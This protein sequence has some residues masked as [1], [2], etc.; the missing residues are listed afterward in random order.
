MGSART[1][2]VLCVGVLAAAL[3]AAADAKSFTFAV[4]ADAYV[5][6]SSANSNFGGATTLRAGTSPVTRSYLRFTVGGL[7]GGT[8]TK[9]TL[10][11]QPAS[12]SSTGVTV[13]RVTGSWSEGTITFANAPAPLVASGDPVSGGVTSGSWLSVNVTRFVTGEGSVSLALVRDSSGTLSFRSQEAGSGSAPRLVVE[14]KDPPPPPPPPPAPSPPRTFTYPPIADAY[15]G[16][17]APSTSFGTDPSLRV[18]ATPERRSYLRFSVTGLGLAPT[19]ATLRL[20]AS[21]A[22]GD[23][24]VRRVGDTAW[25][26]AITYESAPPVTVGAA[27][28]AAPAAAAGW[29]DVDV[30]PFVSGNGP[31]SLALTTTSATET[32]LASRERGGGFAPQLIVQTP[33]VAPDGSLA[34]PISATFYYPWFPDGWNQQG[35]NCGLAPPAGSPATPSG[36]FTWYTPSAGF[37]S[38]DGS[39]G[40]ATIDAHVRALQAAG[41]EA[42]IASWW[43]VGT[44]TDSR[45]SRLLSR[46]RAL[47]SPLKWALYYEQEGYGNPTV[48]EIQSDLAYIANTKRYSSNSAYLRVGGAPVLFVYT[49]DDVDCSVGQ[50]WQ[51]AN[52]SFG[53]HLVFKVFWGYWNCGLGADWHQYGPAVPEDDQKGFS[54]SISP[55]FWKA[56]EAAPRLARDLARWTANIA[57]MRAANVHWRL[58]TSFNEWGE[59]T[60]IESANE[61]ATPS[62]YGAYLDA[63]RPS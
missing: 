49:A 61:W 5:N 14:T 6:Q 8:V 55:G 54:F 50:R 1:L 4:N 37:Y 36:C 3:P 62:R 42:A 31:V 15:V 56:G 21:Q 30:T 9:A 63:L 60:S 19:K 11:L 39:A 16:A 17:D 57:H 44:P 35:Y 58:V 18:A 41:Q 48:A 43:G 25:T 40:D 47:A 34:W 10:R 12:T 51:T 22:T 32:V 7:G 29:V 13:R 59:G 26:E 23:F 38:L 45:I 27:D 33:S 52:Q 53:F 46:T 20:Q 24:A 2:I 28:P